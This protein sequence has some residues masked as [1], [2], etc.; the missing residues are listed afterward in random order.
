MDWPS[1]KGGGQ[2]GC[3]FLKQE[4]CRCVPEQMLE[5][6]SGARHR[7]RGCFGYQQSLM[8][9]VFSGQESQVIWGF[10]SL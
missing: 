5:T 3:G 8:R 7:Q 6:E 1:F 4:A 10:E 9:G 2:G